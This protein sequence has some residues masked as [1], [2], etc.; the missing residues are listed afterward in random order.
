[1]SVLVCAV[2]IAFAG[3]AFGQLT[4]ASLSGVVQDPTKA[5]IPGVTVR[6][7]NV[8]TGIESTTLTNESGSYNFPS[9][10]PGTYDVTAELS[11]FKAAAY[12]GLTIGQAQVRQDFTLEVGAATQRVDI[13]ATTD[14]LLKESSAS[15]GDVLTE[16]RVEDL[17]LVGANVLDLMRV[18]PG[19]KAGQF[20]VVGA[21]DTDNFAGQY[22]NTVNVSRD[23]LSVNS[24]RNDA[25]IFGLQSNTN[26][27]P[28]LVGEIRLILTP[29][30]PEY[31]GNAQI[32]ISSRSGT[33]RFSG[34]ATWRIHNTALDANTWSNNHTFAPNPS[35]GVLQ[36]AR[37][38]WRNTNDIT[39]SFG[40]PILKNK[41]FFFASWDQQMS[42]SRTLVNASVFTDTARMGIY[43]YFQGWNPGNP[44]QFKTPITG[45]GQIAASVDLFGNPVAPPDGASLRCMSLFGSNRYDEKMNALVPITAA[46]AANFCPGGTFVYGPSTGGL[47]DSQRSTP[48]QSGYIPQLLAAMPHA[49]SFV[50]GDGLNTATFQWVRGRQGSLNSFGASSGGAD[51]NNVNRKQFNI[52]IDEN[53]TAA[54]RIAASW[55]IER[56]DSATAIVN[57]PDELLG[58]TRGRP[59]TFTLNGISTLSPRLLNEARFGIRWEANTDL[60]PWES[61]D[62]GV[63]KAAQSW[64]MKG[65]T[66]AGLGSYSPAQPGSLTYYAAINSN[67]TGMPSNGVINSTFAGQGNKSPLYSFADNVSYSFGRHAFKVGGEVRL[68]RSNGYSS[69]SYPSVTLGAWGASSSPLLGGFTDV[70][71]GLLSTSGST[72]V[73]AGRTILSNMAYFLNGSVSTAGT[74][75]WINSV[76]DANNGTWQDIA[77]TGKKL[78]DQV[79]D[80]YALFVKDD[81]K[82]TGRLTVNLGLRWEYYASPYIKQG[83][84]SRIVNQG[85]G[86]FGVNQP[87]DP[88]HPLAD[89]MDI[90][91]HIYLS[92]YGSNAVG[93]AALACTNGTP[94]PNGIPTSSCDP[95][96]LTASEFVGPNTPNPNKTALPT[97]WTNF[98]PA[99]GLA[100]NVPWFGEGKTTLRAGYQ[101]TYSTPGRSGTNLENVLGSSP[102]ATITAGLTTTDSQY[103]PILNSGRVPNLTDLS[104]IVPQKPTRGP[105]I[106]L[107]IWGRASLGNVQAWDPKYQLPYISNLNVS[108]TRQLRHNMI[109]DVKYVGA[110]QRR[111]DTTF[112]LN[113]FNIFRNNELFQALAD[114]R[115]GKDPVLLDQMF[116]GLDLHGTSGTGYGAVGTVVSNV[117][118]TGAAHLRRNPTF[119]TNLANGNFVSLMNSLWNLNATALQ[120]APKNADGSSIGSIGSRVLRNGCDRMA[121]GYQYVQQTQPGVF[122]QGYSAANATPLRC[123][124]EDYF[125][126]N[127]QFSDTCCL[128][129]NVMLHTNLGRNNYNELQLTYTLRPTQGTT[130]QFTG[131]WNKAMNFPAPYFN[132]TWFVD[133]KHPENDYVTDW[134]TTAFDYRLN[135]TFELPIGPNRLLMGNSS[136]VLGRVLERWTVSV[137]ERNS[138]GLVR[139]AYGAQMMFRSGG[140]DRPYPRP[141]IVGPWV[142]PDLGKTWV[143]DNGWLYGYPT[144]FTNF[145]DP[146]CAS[147]VANGF[148]P[149]NPDSGTGPGQFN[150]GT[151]CTLKGLAMLTSKNTPGAWPVLD[152]TNNPTGQYAVSVL[153][154]SKPGTQGNFGHSHLNV[155]R[156][157]QLDAN[158]SKTFRIGESK[159][160][161]FRADATNI[162]NHPNWGEPTFNIQSSNFGRDSL[163][164]DSRVF[165]AQL[166]VAF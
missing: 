64:F 74:S 104:L 33:N 94:N 135:G 154:N 14:S 59:Q 56:S 146:Q 147:S 51:P 16:Q 46:D 152:A 88:R 105:G 62:A 151:S 163:K 11:G 84:T 19:M 42:S 7:K 110:F 148:I 103:Q 93:N 37:L 111:Q 54:H 1:V 124:P 129:D 43:R 40:G 82:L 86:L 130:F 50:T 155:V 107:P 157:Q 161:Q 27:N 112:D 35:T 96:L 133:P 48:D 30:D 36:A 39:G 99:L 116:A 81:W 55:S 102:G 97:S 95:S 25:N 66:N 119:T 3:A 162:F 10:L 52:K 149:S 78:R 76:A 31:R 136:G 122:S 128:S 120:T 83:F 160:I 29:V 91:P 15:I 137:I 153:Q 117:L 70:L 145:N 118:Q 21:F 106:A 68:S 45:S 141:D 38:D 72:S 92:G 100:W 166:R 9:L 159:Q 34:S 87:K 44:I 98:G 13:T 47:W 123:F 114:A 73:S 53:I 69:Y 150:L 142:N 156:R 58:M 126:T 134:A 164:Q 20:T 127:P 61:P 49:N 113:N 23:G 89:W 67:L 63:R 125:A 140:G 108:I 12:R 132:P 32:Q 80:D 144:V 109:L 165:Q 57:W 4:N 28:D 5:L 90:P 79:A 115:A 8:G 22:A 158:L 2:E 71:P 138:S 26:I 139:D 24:G 6:A 41:T 77:T 101:R 17:P 121:N 18:M 60:A 75:Y 85:L 143:G 131:S 65:G